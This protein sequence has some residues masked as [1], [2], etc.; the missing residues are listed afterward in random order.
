M[1]LKKEFEIL[2]LL[3]CFLFGGSKKTKAVESSHESF[4]PG[5][6]KCMAMTL[7]D[8]GKQQLK[9]GKMDSFVLMDIW[10][11]RIIWMENPKVLSSYCFQPGSIFKVITAY[12]AL[13]SGKI[14]IHRL[15]DCKENGF[16]Y[17]VK[18]WLKKG[19]GKVDLARALAYSC[20][21]YFSQLGGLISTDELMDSAR[22]FG[23]G[24]STGSDLPGEVPGGLP[25]HIVLNDRGR[26][27]IGQGRGV[28]VTGLEVLSMVA[29]IANGGLLLT[30]IAAN[31]LGG[32]TRLRGVIDDGHALNFIRQAMVQASQYGTGSEQHLYSLRLAGKTGTSQWKDVPWRTHGWF[33]GFWPL[34]RPSLAIVVFV[35]DGNGSKQAAALA[36]IAIEGIMAAYVGCFFNSSYWLEKN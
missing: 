6:K 20:N 31:P 35:Y 30:P 18:C 21:L 36:K 29:A 7:K 9:I 24:S 23:L 4:S 17:G 11:G 15:F 1:N 3:V 32:T 22:T 2:L 10:T 26:F 12:A 14:D 19:H 34:E 28:Y 13:V 8:H 16:I 33:M 5:M 25:N 27:A